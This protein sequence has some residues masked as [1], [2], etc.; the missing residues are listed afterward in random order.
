MQPKNHLLM[1]D[2][3]LRRAVFIAIALLFV[4]GAAFLRSASAPTQLAE[5]TALTNETEMHLDMR[6]F[7]PRKEFSRSLSMSVDQSGKAR[8]VNYLPQ[9]LLVL[10]V[11]ESTIPKEEVSNLFG[12]TKTPSFRAAFDDGVSRSNEIMDGDVFGLSVGDQAHGF[13]SYGGVMS[14]APADVQRVAEGLV[15]LWPH[16]NPKRRS[17]AYLRGQKL[18][19]VLEDQVRRQGNDHFLKVADFSQDVQAVVEAAV[20]HPYGFIDLD[21]NQ[22]QKLLKQGWYFFVVAGRA[23]YQMNLFIAH[24]AAPEKPG[25]KSGG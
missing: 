6:P 23:T 9:D 21:E 8:G 20:S 22:Y 16:M 5:R 15:A 17:F 12:L 18:E 4:L 2:H 25:I 7:F 1:G 19:K 11:R 13:K 10:E 14:T 3:P 24:K